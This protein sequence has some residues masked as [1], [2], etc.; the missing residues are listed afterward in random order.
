MVAST[1]TTSATFTKYSIEVVWKDEKQ[2]KIST[3]F[4]A[5]VQIG[6][7]IHL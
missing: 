6:G 2:R 3:P 5:S 4:Q 1:A 7:Y